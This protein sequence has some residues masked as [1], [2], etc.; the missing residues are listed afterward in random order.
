MKIGEAT[1]DS[2]ARAP[3]HII[4]REVFERWDLTL[5]ILLLCF[6]G[7][8]AS[9]P[10]RIGLPTF[11][12]VVVFGVA[13]LASGFVKQTLKAAI[14]NS[15]SYLRLPELKKE[16]RG[17]KAVRVELRIVQGGVVTG[18]DRGWLAMNH[19]GFIFVGLRTRAAVSRSYIK[20]SKFK[21]GLL[22]DRLRLELN[23]PVRRGQRVLVDF[24]GDRFGEDTALRDIKSVKPLMD[25]FV[26]EE[27]EPFEL[28][29]KVQEERLFKPFFLANEIAA[30]VVLGA[31]Y[32]LLAILGAVGR[33]PLESA[34][35][36]PLLVTAC[37]VGTMLT[38]SHTM[39]ALVRTWRLR[40]AG[41]QV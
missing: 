19:E 32:W 23:G 37:L 22:V 17:R 5:F 9:N 18:Q 6:C 24:M 39:I 15:V 10:A 8:L 26:P 30:G 2:W 38:S 40:R 4:R 31:A 28:P 25:D 7:Y 13:F 11:S 35:S 41:V 29:L 20:S 21:R 1:A 34:D 14:V 3:R 12:P 16:L 27:Y 36:V 33:K